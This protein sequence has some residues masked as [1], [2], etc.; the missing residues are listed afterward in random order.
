MWLCCGDLK[1]NLIRFSHLT[2]QPWCCITLILK[3]LIFINDTLMLTLP[4][5]GDIVSF[6]ALSLMVRPDSMY[7]VRSTSLTVNLDKDHVTQEPS[8]I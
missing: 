6:A 2:E 4:Q 3:L 1:G 7:E 5:G 8:R